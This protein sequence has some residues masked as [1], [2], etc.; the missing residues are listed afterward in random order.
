MS[1]ASHAPH[2]YTILAR[3][4]KISPNLKNHVPSSFETEVVQH[5]TEIADF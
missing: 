2:Y 5:N 3:L 1:S 4:M